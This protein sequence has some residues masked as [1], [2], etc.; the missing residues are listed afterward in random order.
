MS[1]TVPVA[2]L[3]K[4]VEA[5]NT[6]RRDNP[7]LVPDL[8]GV[9]F[10]KRNVNGADLSGVNF[11]GADI[12]GTE[13][14]RAD[15]TDARLTNV[16]G[17]LPGS[18]AGADLTRAELPPE[19]AEFPGLS[20]VA[21]VSK[22]ARVNFLAVV[23]SCVFC[24]L[25]IAQTTDGALIANRGV[26]PLLVIDT[27]VPVNGFFLFA[28]AILLAIY[29]Y[30]QLYLQ[31][32]WDGL[33]R[34]PVIFPDGAR[35]DQKAFP[36]LL[37]GLISVYIRRLRIGAPPFAWPQVILS[38]VAAWVLVPMTIGLFWVRYLLVT[39]LQGILWHVVLFALAI[40]F[41]V[42]FYW[43]AH[44]TLLGRKSAR[45]FPAMRLLAAALVLLFALTVS[46]GATVELRKTNANW[47]LEFSRE[48]ITVNKE[49]LKNLDEE[50][51]IERLEPVDLWRANLRHAN[52]QKAILVRANLTGVD[53]TDA[54]L[55]NADL[56]GAIL[57]GTVLTRVKLN[58]ARMEGARLDGAILNDTQ[59]GDV[60]LKVLT[61]TGA[62]GTGGKLPASVKPCSAERLAMINQPGTVSLIPPEP[63]TQPGETVVAASAGGTVS[64][65]PFHDCPA[66]P[67]MVE[68]PAGEFLMGS[69]E[70][71]EGRYPD[72]GPQ[73][74]V[75]IA[76][77]F[78]V[79]KY[80]VTR[81]QFADFVS[82]TN[83]DNGE[84][85][86]TREEGEWQERRERSWRQPGFEQ[87]DDDPVVCVNWDDAAAYVAWLAKKTG[88]R[89][90][91]LSEARWE[92][93]AR[94]GSQSRYPFGDS[95][96]ALCEHGNGAD[97]TAKKQE[98]SWETSNCQDGHYRTAPVGSFKGNDFGVHDTIG[99]VWEWVADCWHESYA[100]APIDGGVWEDGDKGDCSRRV[101]RGGSWFTF[102]RG[103]RSAIRDRGDSADRFNYVGF[104]VSRTLLR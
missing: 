59:F 98:P 6:W 95:E 55:E 9:D 38:V 51:A 20:H 15:L 36:W 61:L 11:G 100:G 64:G 2:K 96:D 24:W 73:H 27:K 79:G 72:E 1:G 69:R 68:I 71:E 78:A 12:T 82:A 70:D 43:R 3:F 23:A 30:L 46:V 92:Y 33:T 83:H 44:T 5:W 63:T 8:S 102:P 52:G 17:L 21:E 89:Y 75:T 7:G 18:L 97:I 67:E 22:H 26:M 88:K 76:K 13:F 39:N 19:L 91:L 84:S 32:M 42:L 54:V 101:L 34:L 41:G 4:D 74:G 28:P 49:E 80:E 14:R 10:R 77:P 40:A 60:D 99:N 48:A 35:L 86:R 104:R 57:S 58:G 85:C 103:L 81:G 29:V 16:N 62:C 37:S 50:G 87:T 53:L 47:R 90:S 65:E 56:R 31:R 25:T 93:M 45:Q 94:A 66:C